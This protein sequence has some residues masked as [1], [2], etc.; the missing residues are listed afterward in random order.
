[1]LHLYGYGRLVS[2]LRQR[3]DHQPEPPRFPWWVIG[4][5]A[6]LLYLSLAVL[7]VRADL[8]AARAWLSR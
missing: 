2:I 3:P 1:M 4:L 6:A 7:A 5:G 8:I